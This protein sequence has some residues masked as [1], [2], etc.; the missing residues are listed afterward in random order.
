MESTSEIRALNAMISALRS[1]V[2]V[3]ERELSDARSD[4]E[5]AENRRVK[6]QAD[7]DRLRGADEQLAFER[8]S[9]TDCRAASQSV[10]RTLLQRPHAMMRAYGPDVYAA[11]KDTY[12]SLGGDVVG[13]P[14][15]EPDAARE[16][17]LDAKEREDA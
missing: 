10:M 3:L 12:V 4:A 13:L 15:P 7:A 5:R 17:Q 11:V 8:A 2:T 16:A 6:A 1:D 14:S 9:A